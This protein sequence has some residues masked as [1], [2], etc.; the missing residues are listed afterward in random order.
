MLPVDSTNQELTNGVVPPN[1]ETEILNVTANVRYL[2]CVKNIVGNEPGIVASY[3]D[4]KKPKINTPS[5]MNGNDFVLS[6]LNAT[7]L[8]SVRPPVP[9]KN[10]F[11]SP[12]LSANLPKNNAN[13]IITA[14]THVINTLVVVS[15]ILTICPKYVGK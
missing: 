14:I 3:V 1:S 9:I 4:K 8:N 7:I 2:I 10:T 13:G 12:I 5:I 15:S 6:K 11:F